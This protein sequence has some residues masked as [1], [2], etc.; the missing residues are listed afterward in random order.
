MIASIRTKKDGRDEPDHD[1]SLIVHRFVLRPEQRVR[2]FWNWAVCV[3]TLLSSV[4][5]PLSPGGISPGVHLGRRALLVITL[6]S[7]GPG[8]WQVPLNLAFNRELAPT[9]SAQAAF[10]AFDT[11]LDIFFLCDVLLNFITGYEID[12]KLVLNGRMTALR[13][14]RS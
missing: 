1:P 8:V 5:V 11:A 12:K 13:Y 9:A 7:T 6:L 2:A 10:R 4:L 3:L 14:L